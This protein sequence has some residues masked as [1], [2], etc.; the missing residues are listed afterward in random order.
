MKERKA[1]DEGAIPKVDPQ[2][3]AK[4]AAAKGEHIQPVFSTEYDEDEDDD[5]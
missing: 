4:E 3:A 1:K 5:Y 2:Q